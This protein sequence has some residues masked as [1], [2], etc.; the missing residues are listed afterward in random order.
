LLEQKRVC[1]AYVVERR[2]PTRPLADSA[3]KLGQYA[4]LPC[5]LLPAV[6]LWVPVG[7]VTLQNLIGG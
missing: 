5:F 4:M 6:M 2:R 1:N 3:Q 7:T